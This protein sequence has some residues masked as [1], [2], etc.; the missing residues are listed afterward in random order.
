M[1]CGSDRERLTQSIAKISA[2]KFS[3]EHSDYVKQQKS[4]FRRYIFE[5]QQRLDMLQDLL[6]NI[7]NGQAN[8]RSYDGYQN[9][10]ELQEAITQ[11]E[12]ALEKAQSRGPEAFCRQ[13][14]TWTR[15]L[16][17]TLDD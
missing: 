9:I 1:N 8:F 16:D 17:H 6:E 14:N 7:R 2:V 3:A 5:L 11:A 12:T 4:G 13:A 15:S 10:A